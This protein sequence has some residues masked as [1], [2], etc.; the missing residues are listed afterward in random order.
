MGVVWRAFDT[1][2]DREVAVK[3]LRLPEWIGEQE[4]PRWYARMG[5]EARAAARLK[6]PGIV[7]VYDRVVTEDG[8]PWIVM[9]LI[10]GT[11]S[12]RWQLPELI[13]RLVPGAMLPAVGTG[14]PVHRPRHRLRRSR[15]G[16]PRLRHAGERIPRSDVR[17]FP[18]ERQRCPNRRR[19]VVDTGPVP[20]APALMRPRAV[21]SI[22]TDTTSPTFRV[23]G[24]RPRRSSAGSAPP[25]GR[26]RDG[27]PGGSPGR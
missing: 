4:R 24:A 1:G 11:E 5:R 9:E 27:R 22:A 17:R 3:E 18:R 26:P 10:H 16:R 12:A 13:G 21:G 6:H 23:N 7:T 19:R 20:R 25:P 15:P 2:L 14:H 8:R